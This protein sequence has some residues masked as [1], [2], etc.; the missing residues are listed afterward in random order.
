MNNENKNSEILSQERIDAMRSNVMGRINKPRRRAARYAPLLVAASVVSVFGLLG[1]GY[2]LG[3][4]GALER[5]YQASDS[6]ADQHAGADTADQLAG[7]T[8]RMQGDS[9]ALGQASPNE[10]SQ[11]GDTA[12]A[13]EH[14]IVTGSIDVTVRDSEAAA[15]NV[16]EQVK[17]LGGRID[18][19]SQDS[20]DSDYVFLTVRVP[21]D[22]VEAF[23]EFIH[24]QGE[25]SSTSLSRLQVDQQVRDLDARIDA[26]K[27]STDRL[28]SIM[29]EAKNTKD[30][31]E[32]ESRL[33][34]RQAELESLLSQRKAL[35]EQ[36]ALATIDVTLSETTPAGTVNPGGFR[37][38]L[39]AGWN[40]LVSLVNMG[41]TA[42]GFV[43][44]WL[45]PVVAV[46]LGARWLIRRRCG[47]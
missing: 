7:P 19:E 2:V 14:V 13:E 12:Q 34:Q 8:V 3:G 38:G 9:S 36:T 31:L 29:K 1:V 30:L 39:I 17:R 26:L 46:A 20:I 43:L 47:A 28:R 32:A 40:S 4:T 41:V 21:G 27:V 37:G 35:G 15:K 10:E 5:N 16:R 25:I 11:A 42:F 45:V 24:A 44:P 22:Q 33:S 23:S 6:R 18:S